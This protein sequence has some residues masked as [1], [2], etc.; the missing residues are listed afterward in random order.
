MIRLYVERN[1]GA[2]V[3]DH[4]NQL[5]NDG[6]SA[7]DGTENPCVLPNDLRILFVNCLA[8]YTVSLF[9]SRPSDDRLKN[10][11]HSA[12]ALIPSLA[13][14]CSENEIVIKLSIQMF[15]CDIIKLISHYLYHDL[16]LAIEQTWWRW[17]LFIQSDA[18][19]TPQR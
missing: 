17:W 5:Q 3:F 1:G 4:L 6:D 8:D 9:G 16:G 12:V 18:V 15:I 2:A 19:F 10:I 11:A 7:E 13:S 14:K